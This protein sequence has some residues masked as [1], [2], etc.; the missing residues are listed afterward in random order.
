ML[1]RLKP[2][3]ERAE[4]SYA[5]ARSELA[6]ARA[7]VWPRAERAFHVEREQKREEREQRRERDGPERKRDRGDGS[8]AVMKL[9]SIPESVAVALA[10][11][12]AA[13]QPR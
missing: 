8:G 11:H 10:A 3:L 5:D 12:V 2:V 9:P 4:R 7:E 13:A 6:A 1:D